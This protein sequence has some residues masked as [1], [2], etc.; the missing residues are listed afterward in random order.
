MITV[1]AVKKHY[2]DIKA[3]DD[4]SFEIRQGE[5]VGLL[6][7]NGAG[8]T[9]LL[10]MIAGILEPGSGEVL[11]KE[12]DTVNNKLAVKK[13][14]GY[15]AENNPLYEEMPVFEYL[16]M[17]ADLRGLK[18]E[19]I[20]QA[21]DQTVAKAGITSVFY[22]PIGE[23]SKGFKQ[24]VGLAAAILADP[25]ILIL[26]EPTEGLDP[27]Q[28]VDIRS[29]ITSLGKEKTVIVSTHVL[30]EATAMCQRLIILDKGKIAAQGNVQELQNQAGQNNRLQLEVAV[31][32]DIKN[33]LT[34]IDGVKEVVS[35]TNLNNRFQY[36]LL[37]DASANVPPRIFQAA[38]QKNWELW[39][40]HQE[41]ASLE[42]VFR[43]LTQ[44]E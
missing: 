24:R 31:A 8:K 33:D 14:I 34:Q 4:V 37:I 18:K 26:D 43:A 20:K 6:G 28:R 15:L 44:K 38:K 1:K 22:R 19:N 9:T 25:E 10:R 42:N 23:L 29:L 13:R 27:N 2:Q 12:K 16:K 41:K 32:T 30:P 3:V 7:P 40:L 5:I 36:Q 11:I 21:I 35:A 17:V 39:D